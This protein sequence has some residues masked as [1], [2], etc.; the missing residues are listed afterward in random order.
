VTRCVRDGTSG[1]CAATADA[2]DNYCRGQYGRA[3]KTAALVGRSGSA[4]VCLPGTQGRPGDP[5]LA[6]G[7][8][9][10]KGVCQPSGLA[11]G[12]GFCSQ[13]CTTTCPGALICTK[14]G[15]SGRCV[16]TC[17]SQDQCAYGLACEDGVRRT[18]GGTYTACVP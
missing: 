17:R 14:L 8:C 13:A 7:E 9:G 18:A 10:T 4:S 15:G 3:Q 12:P 6:A 5:C 2:V 16:E 11:G 1:V